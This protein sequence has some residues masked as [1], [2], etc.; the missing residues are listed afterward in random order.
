MA[1]EH[2]LL[3]KIPEPLLPV[4]RGEKYEDPL[5]DELERAG[6]GFVNG[7]G[8][9]ATPDGSIEYCYLDVQLTDLEGGI[10][11]IRAFLL[12]VGAP[13]DTKI[14]TYDPGKFADTLMDEA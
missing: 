3:V 10:S 4:Q 2:F 1:S 13:A 6:L 11:L 5:S 9:K 14:T 7:G 8:T 12:R